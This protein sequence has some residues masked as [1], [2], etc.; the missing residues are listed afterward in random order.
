M[1]SLLGEDVGLRVKGI[2]CFRNQTVIASWECKIGRAA[3][4][5]SLHTEVGS[6]C[7]GGIRFSASLA[8]G[9]SLLQVPS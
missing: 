9:A 4:L 2:A 7:T 5:S 1:S 3:K 8:Y 6:K